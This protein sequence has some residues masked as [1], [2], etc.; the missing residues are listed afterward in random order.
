[1]IPNKG[2]GKKMGEERRKC[3][4]FGCSIPTEVIEVEG[5]HKLVQGAEVLDFS[6]D[7]LKLIVNFIAPEPGSNMALKLFLPEKQYVASVIG[8][9][10]WR[11][12]VDNKLEVGIR[13][14]QMENQ[15]KGE[16]LSWVFPRWVEKEKKKKEALYEAF[17][18]GNGKNHNNPPYY[19]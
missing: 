1:M 7:G 16:V 18:N 17:H 4:R 8:E 9:I 3:L 2:N 13:I 12:Y 10:I 6:R 15:A 11:K 19:R 5:E 14:K